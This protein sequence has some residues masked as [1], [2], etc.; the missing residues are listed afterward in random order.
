MF[1]LRCIQNRINGE[2]PPLGLADPGSEGLRMKCVFVE[3]VR[4]THPGTVQRTPQHDALPRMRGCPKMRGRT[5]LHDQRS[6]EQ[7]TGLSQPGRTREQSTS[8]CKLLLPRPLKFVYFWRVQLTRCKIHWHDA[9][10]RANSQSSF[11]RFLHAKTVEFANFI[12]FFQ[13]NKNA[14]KK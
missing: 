7:H 2:G 1:C 8:C 5:I 4:R 11:K 13:K 3:R 9:N 14:K 6:H 12:N 10:W